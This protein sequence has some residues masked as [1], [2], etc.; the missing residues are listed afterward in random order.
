MRENPNAAGSSSI[1]PKHQS[2][3]RCLLGLF[4]RRGK[5]L[6]STM[7]TVNQI[8]ARGT[9]S[10]VKLLT[11]VPP[12]IK[13]FSCDCRQR[14]QWHTLPQQYAQTKISCWFLPQT[15]LSETTGGGIDNDEESDDEENFTE[16][17]TI[18]DLMQPK[19]ILYTKNLIFKQ[20]EASNLNHWKVAK[21]HKRKLTQVQKTIKTLNLYQTDALYYKYLQT[22]DFY[23]PIT[24]QDQT[25]QHHPVQL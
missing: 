23:T 20:D 2:P 16:K 8:N 11:V 9:L 24:H 6:H 21:P 15:F 14:W 22:S 12:T 3:T 1:N 25:L 19:I 13:P 10:K 5:S 17:D 18:Q 7:T 4:L